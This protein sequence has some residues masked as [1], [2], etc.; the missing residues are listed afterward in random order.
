MGAPRAAI[1]RTIRGSLPIPVAEGPIGIR[2]VTVRET[3]RRSSK[4][5]ARTFVPVMYCWCE[6]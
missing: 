2:S 1:R 6:M 4:I 3:P 5:V